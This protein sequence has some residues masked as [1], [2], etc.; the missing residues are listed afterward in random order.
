MTGFAGME[1]I[2][3]LSAATFALAI[4]KM[5]LQCGFCHTEVL[6]KNSKFFGVCYKALDL[7]QIHCHVLSNLNHNPMLFK[8]IN[9]YLHKGLCIMQ[10]KHGSVW[11]ALEAIL[12]LL[13]LLPHPQDGHLQ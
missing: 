2:T 4:L 1:P 11:V 6:D 10:N 8:N 7:L 13:E 9:G 12:L 5:L 3:N